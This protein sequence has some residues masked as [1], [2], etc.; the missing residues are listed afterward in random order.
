VCV[1]VCVCVRACVRA[2][3]CMHSCRGGIHRGAYVLHEFCSP[4]EQ[5][6]V[7]ES[8]SSRLQ[9]IPRSSADSHLHQH[10]TKVYGGQLSSGVGADPRS[11]AWVNDL[12]G[13]LYY[14]PVVVLGLL[15][16]LW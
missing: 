12:G 11:G 9:T 15:Y 14:L 10:S 4:R 2:C 6:P 3:M 8:K 1:C 16:L 5:H 7:R 13:G